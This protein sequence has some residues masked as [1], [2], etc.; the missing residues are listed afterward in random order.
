MFG[1]QIQLIALLGQSGEFLM[2]AEVAG[3]HFHRLLPACDT[4]GKRLIDILKSLLSRALR[5]R[6]ATLPDPI[7]DAARQR[8]LFGLEAQEGV[9]ERGMLVCGIYAHRLA[10]LVARGFVLSHLQQRVGQVL[11]NGRAVRHQR[12]GLT[13]AR[14]RLIVVLVAQGL[15]G[16]LQRLISRI[17]RLCRQHC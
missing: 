14:D 3:L 7:E 15:V 9:F 2:R 12:D 11:S 4:R 16:A 17:G 1:G 6:R 8:L 5:A 13:E 10:E